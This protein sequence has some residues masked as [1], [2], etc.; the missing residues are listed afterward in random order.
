LAPG[1]ILVDKLEWAIKNVRCALLCFGKHDAGN[2]HIIEYRAYL[3]R[4]AKNDARMIPVILP[5]APEQP[6]LP[7]FLRQALWVDMRNWQ[8]PRSDAFAR[9]QCGIFGKPPGDSPKGFSAREV[10]EFQEDEDG[11]SR[12]EGAE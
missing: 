8:A 10:W 3:E 5:N 4:W 11:I 2:W 12:D 7:T 1:D 9:L 6:D